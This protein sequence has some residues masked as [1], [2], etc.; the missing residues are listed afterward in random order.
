AESRL[1]QAQYIYKTSE[2]AVAY[3]SGQ[4]YQRY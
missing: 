2:A 1:A 3:A 4:D